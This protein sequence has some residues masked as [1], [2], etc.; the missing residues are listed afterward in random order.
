[1]RVADIPDRE[2]VFELAK[3]KIKAA[4]WANSRGNEAN[5]AF[6]LK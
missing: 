3:A 5:T 2:Y 4:E 1:L 6:I